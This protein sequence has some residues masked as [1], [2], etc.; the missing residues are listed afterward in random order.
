MKVTLVGAGP[1]RKGL[2]TLAGAAA[3]AEADVV[4]HDRFV[5]VDILAMI[6]ESAEIIDVG[7]TAGNHPIPQ[8]RINQLLLEKAQQGLNVVRLKG[9]DPFV[10]GRGG[11]ELQLLVEHGVAFEVI[12]GITSA[13]AGPAFAGIPVTHRD[14]A[15]SVHF[16]TGQTKSDSIPNINFKALVDGGGT[17]VFLMGVAALPAISQGCIQA[18]MREETPAAI[19]ENATLPAQRKIIGTVSS[20]PE[21]AKANNVVSPALIIIGEVCLLA[22]DYDWFSNRP[23]H[24]VRVLVPRVKSGKSR[25][26]ARL[27]DLGAQV[28]QMQVAELKPLTAAREQLADALREI[29]QY[30]WLVLTSEYGVQVLFDTLL[31]TE[32]DIRVL[33]KMKVTCVGAETAKSLLRYGIRAD[34]IPSEYNSLALSEGLISKLSSSDKVLIARAES[35]AP[36]LPDAL[37]KTGINYT[38]LALYRSVPVVGARTDD[39]TGYDFVIFTS[40]SA[41]RAFTDNVRN[42]ILSTVKAICIG[43]RTA[44]TARTYEMQVTV[45]EQSTIASLIERVLEVRA[46]AN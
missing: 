31:Q 30:S 15:S 29:E 38:D 33:G 5:G 35:G 9:G 18:G 32:F 1:G 37:R 42:Q 36:D 8:D 13:I 34:Y 25:L 6:P 45:S 20:L 2:L 3:L 26:V 27:A 40:S 46:D 21:L 4:L 12:P 41:V 17:L 19:V 23:L 39:V 28:T 22:D 24:G 11:E 16:I 43:S 10:F 14:Y 7:K 44:E